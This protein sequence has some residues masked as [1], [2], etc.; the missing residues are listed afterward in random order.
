[1]SKLK[2]EVKKEIQLLYCKWCPND[3]E[4]LTE[5]EQLGCLAS[6]G[7]V[8]ELDIEP[9]FIITTDDDKVN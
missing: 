9:P 3:C 4:D 2:D 8:D 6:S 5:E 7:F 1:M